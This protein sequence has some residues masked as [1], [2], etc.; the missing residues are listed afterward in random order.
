MVEHK[1]ILGR[2]APTP[3]GRM[4]LG[5]LFAAL[6]AWLDVRSL[7]G[8]MLLRMEDLDEDRCKPQY[9]QQLGED[10]LWLGL[11]WDTGWQPGDSEY[12][13]SRRGAYYEEAFEKI[14]KQGLL[15][16]CYCNR[17]ERLVVSAPHASDGTVRYSGRCRSLGEEERLSYE[18]A[19]RKAAWRIRVPH[20]K[21]SFED[22]NFGPYTEWLD[23]D[24]GDFILRR[25]DGVYAY[26]LAVVVDDGLMGVTRV[27]RGCDLLSSTPRQLW[28]MEQ[29]GFKP[30]VYCHTPLLTD[31]QGRRLSKRER[32]LD[33]EALRE[34]S[35]P[36]RI[37]GYLA[38]KAGL[39]DRPEAVQAS[40][41]I[42]HFSWEKVGR[43]DR[44]IGEEA[45]GFLYGATS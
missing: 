36:E 24:S 18:A 11:T 1:K 19:G 8:E 4:H 17:K 35:T 38:F 31:H 12:L 45:I 28:L 6:L 2:F 23:E 16:P 41:L 30:P 27:V 21:V 10:L 39:M 14:K 44:V 7:G 15:Y 42:P 22:G 26:Q 13:Q 9:T 43:A 5:N 37:I 40:E 33:M 32:D 3:S 25:S 29:L 34:A 20:R